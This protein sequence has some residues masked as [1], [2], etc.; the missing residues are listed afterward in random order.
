MLGLSPQGSG[1]G[2]GLANAA[3]EAA[4]RALLGI[5]RGTSFPGSPSA[6]DIF[7]RTDRNIEYVRSGSL[8]LS[9]QL[10]TA[11]FTNAVSVSADA[12]V[13]MPVPWKGVYGLYLVRFESVSRFGTS[14]D[15]NVIFSWLTA[16]GT[17]TPLVSLD[18]SADVALEHT[19]K[20]ADI[21][22]V[23]DANAAALTVQYD[24]ETGATTFIGGAMLHY[25]LI[26]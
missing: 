6:G 8:W 5:G 25:R 12:S 17:G 15:W 7:I 3:D 21:G 24:E 16:A 20:G 22:A 13:F 10:H 23:L 26:G 4:A 14:S 11:T 1:Y 19:P 2:Q 9:T 18:G